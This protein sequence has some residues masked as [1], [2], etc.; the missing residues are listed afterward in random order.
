MRSVLALCLTA[1]G[2]AA[3]ASFE[4][5]MVAD[6]GNGTFASRK[7]HRFDGDNGVYLGSFGG[8]GGNIIGTHLNQTTNS[9]FVYTN[10]FRLAEYDYNTGALKRAYNTDIGNTAY[11]MVVVRPNGTSAVRLAG[12]GA[13]VNT[14]LAYSFPNAGG[15]GSF[16]A[17]PGYTFESGVWLDNNRFLAYS[18]SSLNES[19]AL[20]SVS[21]SGL[22]GTLSSSF[23]VDI[24]APSQMTYMSAI[25]T[26]VH[27]APERLLTYFP[28]QSTWGF[29]ATPGV[30]NRHSSRAHDGFFTMAN[31]GGAW[32]LDKYDSTFG[33]RGQFAAGMVLNPASMQTVLAPEPGTM[34][35]LGAGLVALL[36]RRRREQ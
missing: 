29:V 19:V 10:D 20:Y 33:Q 34:L 36:R 5:V 31:R 15:T 35:A 23:L 12:Y 17:L 2:V 21:P 32:S 3:Q 25:D 14:P 22:S 11:S 24:N 18:I 27:P 13:G 1:A 30:E 8:F 9:L 28:S 4:L 7:I 6:N 26:V 16:S